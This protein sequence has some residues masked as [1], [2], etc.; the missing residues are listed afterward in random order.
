MYGLIDDRFRTQKVISS[1]L[2]LSIKQQE[3]HMNYN[4]TQ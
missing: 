2:G 4:L 1:V 3:A